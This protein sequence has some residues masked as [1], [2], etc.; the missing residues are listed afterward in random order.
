[1]KEGFFMK[2][3]FAMILS[4]VLI[5]SLSACAGQTPTDSSGSK[6]PDSTAS[7]ASPSSDS[8]GSAPTQLRKL[9]VSHQ[10][11]NHGL[12]GY[13]AEQENLFVEAGLDITTLMFTSGPPQNEA[14]G[15]GE[16]DV[17]VMGSPPSIAGGIAYGSKVIGFAADDTMACDYWVRPDSPIAEIS[18]K[19]SGSPDILGD[20]DSWR[21]KSILC[22]VATSAH[23]MLI[24]TLQKLRLTEND[25]K[26]INMEV[27]QAFTAFKAGQGDIVALWDPQSVSAGDEGWVCVSSGPASGE[28][29]YTV[30]V[31]S[32]KAIE[33]KPQEILDWMRVYYGVCDKFKDDK[34]GQAKYLLDFQTENGMQVDERMVRVIVNERPMPT[35]ADQAEL[36]AGEYGQ[37]EADRIT[38]KIIDFFVAQG[39]YEPKDK[40][41]LLDNH[42][43]DDR[44]IK[45]LIAEQ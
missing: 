21:G 41:Y 39:R 40:Q 34:D 18:G 19:V 4:M 2:R 5:A 35:I 44:F 20:A 14:L 3:V 29:M 16:W 10:P 9:T 33:E 32:P 36:F 42:F 1:M 30:I 43:I 28:K 17:G 31:A 37:R 27:P 26:I 8:A 15:A 23:F 6:A 24:A 45:Q 38:E 7:V 25:V 11:H 12:P 13:I 22:P